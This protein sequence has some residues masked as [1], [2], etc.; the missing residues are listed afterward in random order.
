[1]F[2]N[3]NI[4]PWTTIFLFQG[5][6]EH[7]FCYIRQ[8]SSSFKNISLQKKSKM[9]SLPNIKKKTIIGLIERK[10]VIYINSKDYVLSSKTVMT[11]CFSNDKSLPMHTH[12]IDNVL[13]LQIHSEIL[14]ILTSQ[15]LLK[16]SNDLSDRSEQT[17]EV[18]DSSD[19]PSIDDL[20]F[21]LGLLKG[22]PVLFW[23]QKSFK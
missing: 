12:D 10:I 4:F 14:I 20:M 16:E 7:I 22:S 23:K 19:C 17:L 9:I 2:I 13:K 8:I 21:L 18:S 3:V 15:G 11:F 1:M 6:M 5:T